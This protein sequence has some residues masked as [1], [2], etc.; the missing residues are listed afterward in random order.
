M[1]P[2]EVSRVVVVTGGS[3]GMGREMC[4]GFAA[5][6]DRVVVASRKADACEAL[7]AELREQHGVEAI[8]VACHVGRWADCDALVDRVLAEF[9]RIDVLVNNAGMSPLY[10]SLTEITEELWDKVIAVNLKGAFRLG[11]RCGEIMEAGGGGSIVNVSSIAAVAPN[12][13]ELPYATAKAGL[14]ALTVGL[15]HAYAPRVRVNTVMPGP[16]RT[17]IADAWSP[18]MIERF[19]NEEIPLRRIGEAD[20]VVGAVLYL[21]G[22]SASFTTGATIKI[23]GGLTWST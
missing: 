17:D 11:A 20:E 7:A 21:T 16:F 18:E 5:Q 9:G 10:P 8:G 22:P 14:N 12:P 2:D 6:G 13:R 1:G 19:E 4:R 23:D 3:R 15:A